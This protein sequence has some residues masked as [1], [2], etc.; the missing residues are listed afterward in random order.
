ML[1]LSE[2]ESVPASMDWQVVDF[3]GCKIAFRIEFGGRRFDT[4][5]SDHA[6]GF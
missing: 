1:L 4:T 5:A 2:N 6:G 3:I